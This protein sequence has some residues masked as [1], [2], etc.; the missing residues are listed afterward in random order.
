MTP[1]VV[2][3]YR[4]S[5]YSYQEGNCV[6]VA[7]TTGGLAIRDSKNPHG[8]LLH[9]GPNGWHPFLAAAKELTLGR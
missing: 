3:S 4:K 7:P 8:P 6:E 9:I 1:E 5:S 2:G